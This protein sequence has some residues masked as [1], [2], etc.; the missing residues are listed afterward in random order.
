MERF[1]RMKSLKNLFLVLSLLP[2]LFVLYVCTL[3]INKASN[4][5]LLVWQF[6][7]KNISSIVLLASTLGFSLSAL[8][9]YLITSTGGIKKSRVTKSTPNYSEVKYDSDNIETDE[10]YNKSEFEYIERDIRHPSPTLSIPYK[11][12]NRNF[13]SNKESNYPNQNEVD[14][15]DFKYKSD[16]SETKNDNISDDWITSNLEQW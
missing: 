11:I 13:D 15:D 9:I 16:D 4:L 14:L 6:N 2:Y 5:K 12:I 7:N 1:E 8:N 3:N 10:Q